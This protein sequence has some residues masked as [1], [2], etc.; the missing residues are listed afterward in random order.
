MRKKFF[1]RMIGLS[2][3]FLLI[4]FGTSAQ[5]STGSTAWVSART[6]TLKSSTWFF[7]SNRGS[8]SYGDQVSVIQLSGNWAEVRSTTNPSLTGWM[9]AA[10][11]ST[12]RIIPTEGPG[13]ATA[14][15]VALA[16]KGFDRDIENA[17]RARGHL[18]YSDVDRTEGLNVAESELLRFLTEGRLAT[19]DNR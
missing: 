18:N 6:V 7:A 17:Y 8:V 14:S 1:I 5:I 3:L 11:L 19:G 12:R 4:S 15:E 10:N 13:G 9:A 16:G 2:A